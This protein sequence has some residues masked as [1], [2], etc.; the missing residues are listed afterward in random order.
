MY[1]ILS[2]TESFEYNSGKICTRR[3]ASKKLEAKTG[4]Y[5]L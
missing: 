5:I 2:T 4:I 3:D 1:K